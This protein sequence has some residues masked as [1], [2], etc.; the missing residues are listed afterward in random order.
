MHC[1]GNRGESTA[2]SGLGHI[3]TDHPEWRL[4]SALTIAA[5]QEDNVK[6]LKGD[7]TMQPENSA[8]TLLLRTSGSN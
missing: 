7:F 4:R 6:L 1:G 5:G 3:K 2:D 8:T